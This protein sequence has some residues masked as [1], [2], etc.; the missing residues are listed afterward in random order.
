MK[1][2]KIKIFESAHSHQLEAM[3]NVFINEE[4]AG[5]DVID[6]KFHVDDQINPEWEG[7]TPM[8]VAMIMYV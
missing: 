2:V 7:L 8:Y 4:V 5:C 1:N 3:V 6:I